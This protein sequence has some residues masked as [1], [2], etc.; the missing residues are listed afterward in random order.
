MSATRAVTGTSTLASLALATL[1][2]AAAAGCGPERRSYE[3]T[4]TRGSSVDIA[5]S[6][7]EQSKEPLRTSEF[8][9]LDLASPELRIA[10]QAR[11]EES[12]P[13]EGVR[14]ATLHVRLWIHNYSRRRLELR[15]RE[16][17]ATDDIGRTITP[18]EIRQDGVARGIVLASAPVRTAVDVL[19]RL[20]A[21]FDA[22][23]AREILLRWGFRIDEREVRHETTFEPSRDR[24]FKD[25]FEGIPLGR[26]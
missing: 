17:S 26:M 3:P 15:P 5:R 18:S 9:P 19:F 14:V 24:A 11:I 25:P 16:F 10:A 4:R 13:V 8:I 7:S 12:E 2:V 21:G 6:P 22:S 1:L 20:P 23:A